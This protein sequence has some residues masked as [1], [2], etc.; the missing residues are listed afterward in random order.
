MPPFM[1][2]NPLL[3]PRV[4]IHRNT[5]IHRP[6]LND[7]MIPRAPRAHQSASILDAALPVRRAYE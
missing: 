3:S 2:S 4:E 7:Q 5:P 6:L 1:L